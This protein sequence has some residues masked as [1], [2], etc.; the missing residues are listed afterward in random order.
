M[1]AAPILLAAV[2]AG[3]T[4]AQRLPAR[5]HSGLPVIGE[6]PNFALRSQDG[7]EVALSQFRGKVVAVTFIFASCSATCPLLT[8]KMATVQNQLGPDFGAKIA[9]LSITVDPEHDTTDVLRRYASTFSANPAGWK[10]LTGSPATIKQV[11]QQYG[12]FASGEPDRAR[13]HT[14]LTSLIDPHGMLR[15]QYLGIRFDPDEF[16]HDLQ[17]LVENP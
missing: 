17:S 6:A 5:D 8:A 3:S 14:N 10:F 12:V 15:V 11:E 1:R 2:L 9:F 7:A 16:R 13:D 4:P